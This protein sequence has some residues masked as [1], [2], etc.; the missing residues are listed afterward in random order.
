[1]CDGKL[2]TY[3][4][5]VSKCPRFESEILLSQKSIAVC[6]GKVNENVLTEYWNSF[7]L[8]NLTGF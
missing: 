1:M 6:Q 5:L 8:K 7:L 2:K 4:K 3:G